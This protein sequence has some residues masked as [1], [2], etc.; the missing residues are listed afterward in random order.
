MKLPTS[1][2]RSMLLGT[3]ALLL[4]AL[5]IYVVIRS[6][7][8][9]PVQI[10]VATVQNKPLQPQ[11]FGIGTVEARYSYRIGPITAGR[12]KRITVQVGD[13]VQ[14]GQVVAEVEPVDL[15][16]RIIGQ[17]ATVQK[18]VAS[19]QAAEAQLREATARDRYAQQQAIRYAEL[20]Q[21][22]AVSKETAENKLLDAQITLT[23]R[24]TSQA[25]LSVARQELSR[26]RSDLNSLKEQRGNLVLRA[27]A[28]GLV[29]L[30]EVEPGTTVVSG[31][32][33][34]E[35]IDP[36][37][38]WVNVRFDQAAVASL[39]AGQSTQIILRSKPGRLFAG[40]LAR[41]EPKAD[42]VTEE[43]LAKVTFDTVPLPVPP[44]GE[45]VEVTVMLPELPPAPVVPNS[46]IKRYDNKTGV[47][48]LKEGKLH[49][50]PARP[51]GSDLDGLVQLVE[52]VKAG[53]QVVV[54]SRQALNQKT[55]VRVVKQLSGAPK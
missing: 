7:P 49:F 50:A 22:K 41:I 39:K 17:T 29:T 8:L 16:T 15:D 14:A 9:A 38:I 2:Y 6:G 42:S 21:D 1:S 19:L 26:V 10:T 47:W 46:A 13:R 20:I 54:Y 33:V 27:P 11:L 34:I 45:M 30:R 43:T 36:A 40:K 4:L 25:N 37:T 55:R 32:T 18:A 35:V 31:Q 52:G 24:A 3:L 53:D 51:G 5:F 48:L 44:V 28:A 23:A 12:I